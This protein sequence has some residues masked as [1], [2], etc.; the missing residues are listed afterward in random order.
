M[1]QWSSSASHV[2][3]SHSVVFVHL[4]PFPVSQGDGIG[5]RCRTGPVAG[6]F[7][8][9]AGRYEQSCGAHGLGASWRSAGSC[10]AEILQTLNRRTRSSN[11]CDCQVMGWLWSV[12][13]KGS[14]LWPAKQDINGCTDKKYKR[15]WK[16]MYLRER[17]GFFET[18]VY[19]SGNC[20]LREQ[21]KYAPSGAASPQIRR[22]RNP[23]CGV[24]I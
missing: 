2:T 18:V 8:R 9:L 15:S 13:A 16:S 14:C 22:F 10:P 20:G 19:N 6:A 1:G 5:F 11:I 23:Q 12:L 24:H 21:C 4:L 3:L 7:W 17:K